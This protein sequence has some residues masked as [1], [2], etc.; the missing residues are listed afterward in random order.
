MAVKQSYGTLSSCR[1]CFCPSI[2]AERGSAGAQAGFPRELLAAMGLMRLELI[3]L[4]KPE[5]IKQ[6]SS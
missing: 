3:G 2:G 1:N 6:E 5:L 4:W